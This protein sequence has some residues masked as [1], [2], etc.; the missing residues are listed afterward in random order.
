MA[1]FDVT[2][3]K[4]TAVTLLMLTFCLLDLAVVSSTGYYAACIRFP[5]SPLFECERDFGGWIVDPANQI[6]NRNFQR[7]ADGMLV[8]YSFR[9]VLQT[10][11]FW[12][13]RTAA[14]APEES[15]DQVPLLTIVYSGIF[16]G[17][18]ILLSQYPLDLPHLLTGRWGILQPRPHWTNGLQQVVVLVEKTMM[19]YLILE[20]AFSDPLK[21]DAAVATLC[22]GNVPPSPGE[23]CDGEVCPPEAV[24]SWVKWLFTV[25]AFT[26]FWA[27]FYQQVARPGRDKS[28][29]KLG[30]HVQY[31]NFRESDAARIFNNGGGAMEVLKVRP[32]QAGTAGRREYKVEVRIDHGHSTEGR[33]ISQADVERVESSGWQVVVVLLA[34]LDWF[35]IAFNL[36]NLVNMLTNNRWRESHAD[37]T[38]TKER[39][40]V[41]L[42]YLCISIYSVRIIAQP[43]LLVWR[44]APL[45]FSTYVYHVLT[46]VD[47]A[48]GVLLLLAGIEL[49]TAKLL[50]LGIPLI[51]IGGFSLVTAYMGWYALNKSAVEGP[52]TGC[53]YKSSNG[54][55]M[56]IGA[57]A[58][59]CGIAVAVK[60]DELIEGVRPHQPLG[61]VFYSIETWTDVAQWVLQALALSNF[62]QATSSAILA[63][64]RPQQQV[65]RDVNSGRSSNPIA[66]IENEV[67]GRNDATAQWNQDAKWYSALTFNTFL[68]LPAMMLV[69]NPYRD[70][71]KTVTDS[72]IRL[73]SK[74]WIDYFAGS[75]L[76][77]MVL[78]KSVNAYLIVEWLRAEGKTEN[79]DVANIV[80]LTLLVVHFVA[81]LYVMMVPKLAFS[82]RPNFRDGE[83][84]CGCVSAATKATLTGIFLLTI[85]LVDWISLLVNLMSLINLLQMNVKNSAACHTASVIVKVATA[86]MVCF[87]VRVVGQMVVYL[88]MRYHRGS[89]R[90]PQHINEDAPGY[91]PDFRNT[92]QSLDQSEPDDVQLMRAS[93]MRASRKAARRAS[94]RRE[95]QQWKAEWG[96]PWREWR[97]LFQQL[98]FNSWMMVPALLFI[99][100]PYHRNLLKRDKS[101]PFRR[102]HWC[103]GLVFSA[104]LCKKVGVIYV[105]FETV[106]ADRCLDELQEDP[107]YSRNVAIVALSMTGLHS[108]IW[109]FTMFGQFMGCC[110]G[111]EDVPTD[112]SSSEEEESDSD[113]DD[114][115]VGRSRPVSPDFVP[116]YGQE[117]EPEPEPESEPGDDLTLFQRDSDDD[118]VQ[119]PPTVSHAERYESGTMSV[120]PE[121]EP[122]PVPQPTAAIGGSE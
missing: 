87:V 7:I 113:D 23:A 66:M 32:A 46:A 83:G 101:S 1:L 109:F 10:W 25:Q 37:T 3:N 120:E 38:M 71:A 78:K 70:S 41:G 110:S 12:V 117:P 53:L 55:H 35:H 33:W 91:D 84:R 81:T 11:M 67:G 13:R 122:E 36:T 31:V 48:I 44:G 92:S 6:Q 24:R 107:D 58:L 56:I 98:S 47:I 88:G 22:H 42:C 93:E 45:T 60:R 116:A 106:L 4:M 80:S 54:L 9:I 85:S 114:G 76:F 90:R 15:S 72:F 30:D 73:G 65:E 51:L 112:T 17:V 102:M 50:S 111:G 52:L 20:L 16:H 59:M 8:L 40:L 5:K 69:D 82:Q 63:R 118:G 28:E 68:M 74:G 26:Q 105:N 49:S 39:I 29:V 34:F 97:D 21:C 62:L 43:V 64:I 89:L 57:I 19:G 95:Y 104:M 121:P 96:H 27:F 61:S 115:G 99:E 103:I 2:R 77:L 14:A 119:T 75:V 94:R 79:I 18:F 86:S 100:K 108:I